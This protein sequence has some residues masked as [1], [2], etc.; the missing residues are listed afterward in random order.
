[1][2]R[3]FST[4]LQVGAMTA[5]LVAAMMTSPAA[6]QSATGPKRPAPQYQMEVGVSWDTTL[7][8]QVGGSRFWMQGGSAEVHG[9]FYRGLGVVGDITGMHTGGVNSSSAGLDLVTATFGPRYTVSLRH[10][11]YGV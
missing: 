1:M 10:R 9:Q 3:Y 2:H 6:A 5:T 11:R 7:G 4:M 8:E